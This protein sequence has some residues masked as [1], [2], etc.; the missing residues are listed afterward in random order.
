MERFQ[1]TYLFERYDVLII[2]FVGM[3][4]L[5]P[6]IWSETSITGQDEYWLS[7]RTPM[8]TL[9]HG[10]WFTPRVNGEPRLKKPP[11]PLRLMQ[12]SWGSGLSEPVNSRPFFPVRPGYGLPG[13]TPRPTTGNVL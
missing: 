13:K 1:K 11:P 3:F 6:C 7:F 9:A 8:E 2:F 4:L 5:M 10:G 12:K